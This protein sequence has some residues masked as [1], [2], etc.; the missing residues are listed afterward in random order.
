MPIYEYRCNQCGKEFEELVMNGEEHPQCPACGSKNTQ[1]L[2]SGFALG[3][4]AGAGFG[5][6]AP[7]GG[8]C[9]GTGGFT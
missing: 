4:E 2:L 8:G 7:A 9:G 1:R 5:A 6:S 3:G